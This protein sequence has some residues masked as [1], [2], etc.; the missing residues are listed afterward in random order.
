MD[1]RYYTA[2][3]VLSL[4][5]L[6]AFAVVQM[7]LSGKLDKCSYSVQKGRISRRVPHRFGRGTKSCRLITR[8]D[9]L[10]FPRIS[11]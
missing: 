9:V 10:I 1:Q 2:S 3:E 8:C 7:F 11:M 5:P 6:R 4:M